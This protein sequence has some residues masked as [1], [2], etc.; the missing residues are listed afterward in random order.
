V[1]GEEEEIGVDIGVWAGEVSE[2]GASAGVA[3][4]GAGEAACVPFRAGSAAAVVV[5][6]EAP[7]SGNSLAR[8]M[9]A[10]LGVLVAVGEGVAEEVGKVMWRE[11]VVGLE[12]VVM[13]VVDVGMVW[14]ETV[15]GVWRVVVVAGVEIDR[16]TVAGGLRGA[17]V[18]GCGKAERGREERWMGVKES[19]RRVRR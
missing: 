7:R 4:A 10:R 8:K 17:V 2:T 16:G 3:G 12:G 6:Q 11:G 13:E 18:E 15:W 9:A 5:G 14:R 19:V 1:G